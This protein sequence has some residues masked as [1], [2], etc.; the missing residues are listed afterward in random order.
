MPE[1]TPQEPEPDTQA[2]EEEPAPVEEPAEPP[3]EPAEEPAEVKHPEPP[4]GDTQEPVE[5]SRPVDEGLKAVPIH[6]VATAGREVVITFDDGP[7]PYTEMILSILE[8][9]QVPAAFFWLAGKDLSLAEK[10]LAQGHQLGSHTVGHVRLPDLS[11]EAQLEEVGLSLELLEEAAQTPVRYFRPP[12]GSYLLG[13]LRDA[14]YTFRLLPEPA[15]PLGKTLNVELEPKT[16]PGLKVDVA[17]VVEA[18]LD[19]ILILEAELLPGQDELQESTL[20]TEQEPAPDVE[21]T[22]I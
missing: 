15:Q 2:E 16:P 7:S 11:G 13:A 20:E 19:P 12:Y 3:E 17:P 14:G 22:G 1:P 8:E 10:V 9:E 5:Q 21:P 18:V 4:P 6:S